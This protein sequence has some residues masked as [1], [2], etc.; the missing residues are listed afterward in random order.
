M[1]AQTQR[2]GITLLS[3]LLDSGRRLVRIDNM[4]GAFSCSS[5]HTL[6]H[7]NF[8]SAW[9]TGVKSNRGS[10]SITSESPCGPHYT[11]KTRPHLAMK[12]FPQQQLRLNVFSPYQHIFLFFPSFLE[13]TTCI[14]ILYILFRK[15]STCQGKKI[16]L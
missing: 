6:S 1:L 11:T 4:R 12:H 14:R 7:V 13:T 9:L 16:L 5:C 3:S 8:S 10:P 2:A 15:Y